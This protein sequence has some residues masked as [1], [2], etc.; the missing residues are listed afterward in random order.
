MDQPQNAQS[1]PAKKIGAVANGTQLGL[2][3]EKRGRCSS[4]IE[5]SCFPLIWLSGGYGC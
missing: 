2:A 3:S 4:K 5:L 1:V